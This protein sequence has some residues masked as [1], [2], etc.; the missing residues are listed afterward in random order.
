MRVKDYY[1]EAIR[2][3]HDS[4]I[5]L[6]DY[7]V[8]EK[9]VLNMEDDSEKLTYYLQYRFRNKMNEYLKEYANGD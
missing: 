1:I 7:L 8:H 4:L 9:K 2:G 3:R 6:I 5:L